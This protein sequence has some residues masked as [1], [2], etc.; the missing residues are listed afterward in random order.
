MTEKEKLTIREV[1]DVNIA[2]QLLLSNDYLQP[3]YSDKRDCY[4]FIPKVKR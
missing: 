1:T 4:I 3:R 2:N